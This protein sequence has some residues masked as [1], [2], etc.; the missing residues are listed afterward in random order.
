L[1]PGAGDDP[2]GSLPAPGEQDLGSADAR[3]DRLQ[4][5]VPPQISSSTAIQAV[6]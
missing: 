6:R 2:P 4:E 3:D 1:V 5:E